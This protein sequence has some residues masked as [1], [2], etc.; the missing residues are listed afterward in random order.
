MYLTRDMEDV[1][2]K[3]ADEFECTVVFGPRQVGKSTMLQFFGA[4]NYLEEIVLPHED[5]TVTVRE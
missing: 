5:G 4:D 2:K 3:C 1:L